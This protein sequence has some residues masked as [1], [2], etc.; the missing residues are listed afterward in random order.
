MVWE[1]A[2]PTPERGA[3]DIAALDF[4]RRRQRG[5]VRITPYGR[6][7]RRIQGRRRTCRARARVRATGDPEDGGEDHADEEQQLE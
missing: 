4:V 1:H 5:P 2:G 6:G 3:S 7:G